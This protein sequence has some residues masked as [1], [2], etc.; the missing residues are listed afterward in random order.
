MAYITKKDRMIQR[1]RRHALMCIPPRVPRPVRFAIS[2]T[3]KRT[4]M[5]LDQ[6][7]D[8]SGACKRQI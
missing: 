4:D 8:R 2:P 5:S 6:P 7:L 3:P 1:Y